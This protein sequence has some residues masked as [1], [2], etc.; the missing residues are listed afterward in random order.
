MIAAFS[1]LFASSSP[2]LISFVKAARKQARKAKEAAKRLVH[3]IIFPRYSWTGHSCDRFSA[4]TSLAAPMRSHATTEVVFVAL[5]V[6][7]AILWSQGSYSHG[8]GGHAL[9][10]PNS[11]VSKRSLHGLLASEQYGILVEDGG[12]DKVCGPID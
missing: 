7:N 12:E 6:F 11:R 2:S 1:D 4:C 10:S 9:L 3:D 5:L 8:P